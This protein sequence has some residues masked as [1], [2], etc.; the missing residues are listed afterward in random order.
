MTSACRPAHLTDSVL[1][2]LHGFLKQLVGD[3]E[4]GPLT[5]VRIKAVRLLLATL[6]LTP[7]G[8]LEI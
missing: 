6:E 7:D 8:V 3:V 2:D 5:P 4:V 1:D